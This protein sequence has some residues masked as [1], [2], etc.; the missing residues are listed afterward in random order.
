[1]FRPPAHPPVQKSSA[2]SAMTADMPLLTELSR[3]PRIRRPFR[4]GTNRRARIGCSPGPHPG[5]AEMR[6]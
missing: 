2:R 3:M 1:M 6:P 5:G 4:T